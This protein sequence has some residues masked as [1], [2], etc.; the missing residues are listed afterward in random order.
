MDGLST[1]VKID[2]KTVLATGNTDSH[3]QV[4]SINPTVNKINYYKEEIAK[5][6]GQINTLDAEFNNGTKMLNGL[7]MEGD[8]VKSDITSWI[9]QIA[10]EK[11]LLQQLETDESKLVE[12]EKINIKDGILW[13][14]RATNEYNSRNILTFDNIVP[15]LSDDIYD[16]YVFLHGYTLF[17]CITAGG[18][19]TV[20]VFILGG[21]G[22]GGGNHGGGGGAGVPIVTR[23]QFQEGFNYSVTVGAGGI[24]GTN[25]KYNSE[26][27]N[28]KASEIMGNG[29]L[30]VTAYGG[31]YGGGGHSARAFNINGTAEYGGSGGGGM[32]YNYSSGDQLILT[33]GKMGQNGS[34]NNGGSKY[35]GGNGAMINGTA[36]NG[37]GGGGSNGM[38]GNA[39]RRNGGSGGSGLSSPYIPDWLTSLS[40]Y[41][42]RVNADWNN[43]TQNGRFIAAGGGGGAW[44]QFL[45]SPGKGGNGGG[46]DGG[47][48]V[49]NYGQPGCPDP[50]TPGNTAVRLDNQHGLC[51]K[52]RF[53]RICNNRRGSC[54]PAFVNIVRRG[55]PNKYRCTNPGGP[56]LRLKSCP[57]GTTL[58][59]TE[60]T[61]CMS[62]SN[63][64]FNKIRGGQRVNVIGTAGKNGIANTGS[65]GGGGSSTGFPGGSGGSGIVIFRAPKRGSSSYNLS[66][67]LYLPLSNNFDYTGKSSGRAQVYGSVSFTSK[68]NK[69]AAY[70][71]NRL[72]N[73][74]TIPFIN[75]PSF[76]FCYWVYVNDRRYY[77]AVSLCGLNFGNINNPC[78]QCD[79]GEPTVVFVAALPN[80]WTGVTNNTQSFVNK[81][82]HVTYIVNQDNYSMQ[83]YINGKSAGSSTGRNRLGNTK[84]V[85]VI[86]RSGD[87][88]RAFNGYISDFYYFDKVLS[89][90]EI[91]TIYTGGSLSINNSNQ[92][93]VACKGSFGQKII[94]PE[95]TCPSSQPACVGFVEGQAWG[96]CQTTNE[97]MSSVSQCARSYGDHNDHSDPVKCPSFQPVCK[98]HIGGKQWGTCYSQSNA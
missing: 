26:Q 35:N 89:S 37:G 51:D 84:S 90:S 6:N 92:N 78:I 53:T 1:N 59:P 60:K 80:R 87:N 32:A 98:G 40:D 12:S 79:F 43:A 56:W 11:A 28:G 63:T 44:A 10:R 68:N 8:K 64:T 67:V 55:H 54:G 48:C 77:T 24:G 45:S 17:K 74:I 16:Y 31:F 86:G 42:K 3:A 65:G 41:M 76:T 95:H 25:S 96:K 93:L 52:R 69:N 72:S 9:D 33:G 36:G 15:A 66:P 75:P 19:S 71:N 49:G 39:T 38:G 46:G 61:Q 83:L 14:S 81:W 27:N 57:P 85:F 73:F 21:G 20:D 5:K 29:Q 62:N 82:T 91:N 30:V 4:T 22:A 50:K 94:G 97:I 88:G 34:N 58:E 7:Y 70:F 2:P 18:S 47:G 23:L 13:N